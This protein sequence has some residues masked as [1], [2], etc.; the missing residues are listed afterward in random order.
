MKN[1]DFQ[2]ISLSVRRLGVM[3]DIS[4]HVLHNVWL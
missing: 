2:K 3:V 4:V 1:A